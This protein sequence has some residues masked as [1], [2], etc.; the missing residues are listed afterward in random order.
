MTRIAAPLARFA[1]PV[2]GLHPDLANARRHPERS[3][4]AI[5]AS[6]A[7]FGQQKPI[8]V[9][10]R[11]VVIAGNGMLEAARRLKWK[12]IAVVRSALHGSE[13]NAYSIADNRIAELSEWDAAAVASLIESLD[14]ELAAITGFT[15][16]ELKDLADGDDPDTREVAVPVPLPKAVTRLGDLWQLGEHRLLCGDSTSAADIDRLMAGARAALVA[17][18]PP[19]VVDYT[20]TRRPEAGGGKDWSALYRE[21]D[22][23]DAGVFFRDVF[24]NVV[25]VLAPH[26]AIYC[27]HAHKRVPELMAAW[28]GLGI[29]CHQEIIWV[30]PAAVVGMVFWHFRHEPCLMGWIE[31]SK[32]PHD[33][34]HDGSTVWADLPGAKPEDLTKEQLVKLV[35]DLS[36]VWE[37]G[38][39]GGKARP[40]GNEHPTQKPVEL[41]ARPMRKHTRR[42]DVVLEPFSGSGTQLIAAEQLGRHCRAMEL[43]PVFVDV[44]IRRW[45]A[46]TGRAAT[47]DGKAWAEI[48]KARKVKV[49]ACPPARPTRAPSPAAK[50]SPTAGIATPTR[51]DPSGPSRRGRHRP[52]RPT[53]GATGRSGA[54]SAR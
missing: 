6:L 29:L 28:S 14:D 41:F 17:T 8:V 4:A 51:K 50:A 1:R 22:I 25:R 7:R 15:G 46:L 3:I 31:G 49:P 27:W 23:K 54:S 12:T 47:L 30:K 13:R 35:K 20:G 52:S 45:Q 53:P 32:P 11:G 10:G 40:T 21:I 36:S 43:Q 39:E 9:D 34:I 37:E 5:A 19:Y 48:A 38:W 42:G 33:G 44:A 24:T 16:E 2:K 18:D 26:A